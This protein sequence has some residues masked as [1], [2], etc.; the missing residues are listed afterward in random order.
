[1]T[2]APIENDLGM[3]LR[4]VEADTFTKGAGDDVADPG[5]DER[6]RHAVTISEPFSVAETPVTN[7]QYE[8]FDETHAARR[9]MRGFSTADDEAAIGVSWHDA[10]AFCA[11]LRERTGDPYRLPTEAEWEY[12]CRAGTDTPYHT[13][14]RLPDACHRHQSDEWHPTPV[15]LTVG[16]TPPNPLGLTDCHGLVEEWCLDWHASYPDEPRTD[17]VGPARGVARV[18]RGGSHNTAVT[19]LRSA[20]R[21]AALPAT[22]SWLIGFRPVISPTRPEPTPTAEAPTSGRRTH[23]WTAPTAR[24]EPTFRAPRRFVRPAD[25]GTVLRSHNHCP[26]VTWCRDG[27]LLAIWFSTEDEAAREMVILGSRLPPDATAWEPASVFFDVADRNLTGSALIHD[28]GAIHHFNGVGAASHWANLAPIMRTSTDDGRTWSK[29]RFIDPAFT[30]RHQVIAGAFRTGDGALV[31]PCDAVSSGHGGTAIHVSPDGG[32]TWRDPGVDGPPPRFEAGETGR[33]IAGIHAGVTELDDGR[34]LAFGRG[35]AIDGRMPQSVSADGGR[36][37][38]YAASP[39]PPISS[40]QRLVLRRLREGPL[41]F[42]S[43]TDPSDRDDPDGMRLRTPGGEVARATGLFAAVSFDEGQR[44]P[45]RRLVA[46]AGPSR[47]YDGG[48]WTDEFTASETTAEPM[49]YLAATQT[50]DG[51]I[52]LCS[53]ALHY[54][55]DL[56]WLIDGADVDRD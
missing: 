42:V 18:T 21:A 19:H 41:L 43:F 2:P 25:D 6:P 4:P 45:V 44:W 24:G 55:F 26:A 36:T 27:S 29:P 9:G 48:A 33:W 8:R 20:S 49:G 14:D 16:R 15:E 1:M 40:G 31:L 11:W 37:W 35:D 7:A 56:D 51:V 34:L 23:S 28:D 17:P 22:R 54:R 50:P 5:R 30:Y 32:A 52:H 10:V 46:P 53:S 47:T 13:G 39:F 3:R 12:A 38:R